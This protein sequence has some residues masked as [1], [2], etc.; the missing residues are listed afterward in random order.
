ML[1][2][3]YIP[4]MLLRGNISPLVK[5]RDGDMSDSCNYRPITLS[6]IFIQMYEILQKSKFEYFLPNSDLQFAFKPKTSTLHA[7]QEKR[8]PLLLIKCHALVSKYVLH[9][10]VEDS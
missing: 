7:Y 8:A 2:H 3:S 10:E 5:D 6:S 9:C 1:Q 4:H